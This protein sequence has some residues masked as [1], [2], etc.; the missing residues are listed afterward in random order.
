MLP[1]KGYHAGSICGVGCAKR[2][3]AHLAGGVLSW[4][5]VCGVVKDK[6]SR[7]QYRNL[8]QHVATEF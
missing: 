8:L 1:P 7:R 2:R 5:G 4:P 3:V 6:A